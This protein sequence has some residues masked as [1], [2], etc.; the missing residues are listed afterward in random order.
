MGLNVGNLYIAVK[1]DLNP[2]DKALQ[3]AWKASDKRAKQIEK[4]FTR[5]ERKVKRAWKSMAAGIGG[6]IAGLSVG[7]LITET[8]KLADK[9]TLLE[10][11]IK[12]V[13]KSTE[14]FNRVNDALFDLAQETRIGF[15]KTLEVYARF[16]RATE[17]LGTSQEDL[18]RI[19][20]IVN[21]S[22]KISGA[23]ATEADAALIQFSQGL[24]AGALRGQELNSVMEQTPAIAN[25]IADGMGIARTEIRKMA[26]DGKLTAEV[27]T[28]ALLAQGDAIDKEFSQIP[29]TVA[30]AWTKISN[31]VGKAINETNKHTGATEKLADALDYLNSVLEN[32]TDNMDR[33]L[34]VTISGLAAIAKIAAA[35]GA[36]WLLPLVITKV[37]KAAVLLNLT[38]FKLQTGAIGVNSALFGTSVSAELAAG[39]LSK[40]KLAGMGLMAFFVG[41]ELGKWANENFEEVRLAGLAAIAGITEKWIQFKFNLLQLGLD[42]KFGYLR[43][44]GEIDNAMGEM[45]QKISDKIKGIGFTVKNPFGD[46]FVIGLDKAASG[47]DKVADRLKSTSDFTAEHE[48]AT[49]NLRKEMGKA[50]GIHERTVE[51]LIEERD[52]IKKTGE[53][54]DETAGKVIDNGNKVVKAT[55]DNVNERIKLGQ[56]LELKISELV[57]DEFDHKLFVL[58][59][60]VEAMEEVAGKDKA[61]QDQ[62]ATYHEIKQNEILEAQK[63]AN[64]SVLEDT[65]MNTD[66]LKDLNQTVVDAVIR[67]EN[68]KV[69]VSRLSVDKLSGFAVKAAEKG[70][71]Q[72]LEAIGE[73][74]GAWVGLGVS[75]SATEGGSW[76]Q[77]LASGA[78]YLAGA[79]AAV[80]AGKTIGNT[81]AEGGW[82]TD[83]PDGGTIRGG[84]GFRDDVFLGFTGGGTIAN[85]GMANE[86]VMPK[87]QTTKYLPYLEAMRHNRFESGGMLKDPMKAAEEMNNNGFDIFG[88]QVVKDKNWKSAMYKAIA[89]YIGSG[90]GMIG[91]KEFG[92]NLFADGGTVDDQKREDATVMKYL[93][94]IN[95]ARKEGEKGD[96]GGGDIALGLATEGIPFDNLWEWLR[97]RGGRIGE[98]IGDAD[99]VLAVFMED[100]LTPGKRVTSVTFDAMLEQA[101]N[102]IVEELLDTVVNTIDPLGIMEDPFNPLDPFDIFHDGTSFVPRT[103][104]ALI[105]RGERILSR[106]DNRD[107]IDAVRNGGS[108][109]S[110][111]VTIENKP[112]IKVF[113]G[114]KELKD[115]V[116]MISDDLEARRNRRGQTGRTRLGFAG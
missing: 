96:F 7:H 74:V 28:K 115:V 61:L 8:L 112:D 84:T 32:V 43:I 31:T 79:A 4:S 6:V 89:W 10:G 19:T 50:V 11:R 110:G 83:H 16:A 45:V 67:G 71:P 24:A 1:G 98:I 42:I 25:A 37:H 21:K 69:A 80:L 102:Q 5:M 78:G 116:V 93:D 109:M 56:D 17:Q 82:L 97:D 20:D 62:V 68:V 94:M 46:D 114:T 106:T 81:F 44:M 18:V 29:L 34:D 47:L 113:I 86:Y 48:E 107:L 9:Y 65:I 95:S 111:D 58:E 55:E 52:W 12:L 103:G 40:M 66:T 88:D 64:K 39:S 87:A 60:E 57:N 99:R 77:R 90:L 105:E 13:T 59:K 53:E 23:S 26:A 22:I 30:D 92:H 91:G 41:W 36:L 73:A 63:A 35:G 54:S 70:L 2:L 108:G 85:W 3:S 101:Y 72:V 76:Q 49:S 33:Y 14:E 104:P 15:D 38:M 51:I 100:V 27:V 75:E